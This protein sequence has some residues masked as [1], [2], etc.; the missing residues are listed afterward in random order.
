MNNKQKKALNSWMLFGFGGMRAASRGGRVSE[1]FR[2]AFN[3]ART[4]GAMF[5]L[6][7]MWRNKYLYR[8]IQLPFNNP[9]FRNINGYS[10]WTTNL[11]IARSFATQN[12][13]AIPIILRINTNFMNSVPVINAS[14]RI[15]GRLNSKEKEYILPPMKMTLENQ[16]NGNVIPVRSIAVNQRWAQRNKPS[17]IP[18][19]EARRLPR[20]A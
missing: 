12:G 7:N 5:K 13:G 4:L 1:N 6:K 16:P 18:R 11:N 14:N 20:V 8:G 10:S 17:I 15:V 2:P 9:K 3:E 19:M